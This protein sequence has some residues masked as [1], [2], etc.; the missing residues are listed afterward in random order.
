MAKKNVT[1]GAKEGF[2]TRLKNGWEAR[3]KRGRNLTMLLILTLLPLF[4]WMWMVLL[5]PIEDNALYFD[6]AAIIADENTGALP[7]MKNLYEMV[8]GYGR[9]LCNGLFF[10]VLLAVWPNWWSWCY[11]KKS[12]I[13]PSTGIE[14]SSSVS[15]MGIVWTVIC[16]FLAAGW[17]LLWFFTFS[18]KQIYFSD[19]YFNKTVKLADAARKL[20]LDKYLHPWAFWV[21]LAAALVLIWFS[22]LYLQIPFFHPRKGRD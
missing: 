22:L 6:Q 20:N 14:S 3:M 19:I 16:S 2:F 21:P 10:I 11:Y 7:N 17:N 4:L 1:T 8:G 13:N 9:L 12:L 18:V 15:K 5:I